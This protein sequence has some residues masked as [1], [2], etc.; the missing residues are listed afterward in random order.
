MGGR[1]WFLGKRILCT[2]AEADLPAETLENQRKRE[3]PFPFQRASCNFSALVANW[4]LY[5]DGEKD[6]PLY[7]GCCNCGQ[8]MVRIWR[9]KRAKSACVMSQE[10]VDEAAN[11][12]VPLK[13]SKNESKTEHKKTEL[14]WTLLV[15]GARLF[16]FTR[17]FCSIAKLPHV[18]RTLLST[19]WQ[20]K[21][22][23]ASV[24]LYRHAPVLHLCRPERRRRELSIKSVCSP[25]DAPT[26][27][28]C[29]PPPAHPS[30]VTS[31]IPL[32]NV[33]KTH[34]YISFAQTRTP[35]LHKHPSY[36][37]KTP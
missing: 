22:F 28:T 4:Q 23:V 20:S 16:Q 31:S 9:C 2:D 12:L 24:N 21:V 33:T 29:A 18:V 17:A 1:R 37:L 8:N 30:H 26:H 7:N 3:R 11:L 32:T 13:Y 36:V 14:P 34:R 25:R 19:L 35:L 5:K 27:C 15:N 6:L 10:K